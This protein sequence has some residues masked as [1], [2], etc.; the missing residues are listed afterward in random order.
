MGCFRIIDSHSDGLI[1][2]VFIKEG[3]FVYEWEPL[4]LIKAPNGTMSKVEFGVSG[5][6]SKV[7]VQQGDSVFSAMTLAVLKEDN[8]PSGCD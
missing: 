8:Q 2:E 5:I 3:N 1:E 4:F 6:I 7:N